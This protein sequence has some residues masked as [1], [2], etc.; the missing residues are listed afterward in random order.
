MIRVWRRRVHVGS[1]EGDPG[2]GLVDLPH[3]K[4]LVLLQRLLELSWGVATRDAALLCFGHADN[5]AGSAAPHG[6]LCGEL[7][8]Q[9][10][11]D[12]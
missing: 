6:A 9:G 12:V 3:V 7:A 1:D 4:L 10:E 2:A 5:A 8:H 11:D